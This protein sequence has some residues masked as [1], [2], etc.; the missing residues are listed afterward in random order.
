MKQPT[1]VTQNL[2]DRSGIQTSA[3]LA[4]PRRRGLVLERVQL[5]AVVQRLL[6]VLVFAGG[7]FLRLW[8]I[9]ALGFNTD[10]AVYAGQAAG[11]VGDPSLAP[12]FP[13]F[14][15][16]PLLFQFATALTFGSGVNDLTPRLL[17]VAI[18]LGTVYLAYLI[19]KLLYGHRIGVL[20]A[21]ILAV[22]P[23]HV[24]VTRQNLLDG[25]LTFCATLSLY[26]MARFAA[27]GRP[28][29]L[30][31]MGTALGL[32]FM[33]KETGIIVIGAF[34]AFLA[35]SPEIRV[36]LRDL[37]LAILGMAMIVVLFP[38]SL[39]LAGGLGTAQSYL[40]W[41]LFRRP[42]HEWSFY[43]AQVTLAIGPLV[44]LVAILGLW[45]LRRER[46]WREKLL[47]AWIVVPSLFFELW[48]TKGFQYLLVVTPAF[49]VLAGRM[50]LGWPANRNWSFRGLNGAWLRGLAVGIVAL[51]LLVPSWVLIQ[52]SSSS[53]FLAGSGGVPGGREAGLWMR[54]N[55][56]AGSLSLTIG[57]SMANVLEFYG[58]RK[59]YGLSVSPN[60]LHRN[61]SYE[62]VYNPDYQI[63]NTDLQYLVWDSFSAA[64][65]P[66]FAQK[67]L[68][69]VKR[70]HGRAVHTESVEV[71]TSAGA[72]AQTPVIV[73][74]EVRP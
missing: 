53:V 6:L 32:T 26:L 24:T 33:T 70:Y 30:Y 16:H 25:P 44:V 45:L 41:Q 7:A 9:N 11:I 35:L 15:A 2:E 59:A 8:Q 73:I 50:L 52:P 74:Y 69:Y 17:S 63:R 4:P 47:V 55:V 46:S 60:P 27:S 18:G 13:V 56:P 43:P 1:L 62:P 40:V 57:P 38:I 68:G 61:P 42:N 10:E 34:F 48:P 65:S 31:A 72:T 20:T 19:A 12:Y 37:A 39:A 29:W 36:R 49:A 58:H 3:T 14:R 67:L 28:A 66:F 23:Y 54:S 22:M 5:G 51:S 71:S 64:R 21:F